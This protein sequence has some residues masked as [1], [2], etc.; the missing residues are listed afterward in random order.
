MGDL[1]RYSISELYLLMLSL[2][3]SLTVETQ[4]GAV[5]H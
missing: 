4:D 5:P 1:I 3:S 2:A